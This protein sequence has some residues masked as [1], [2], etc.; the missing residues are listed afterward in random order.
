M[1]S[2]EYLSA[3]DDEELEKSN[4]GTAKIQQQLQILQSLIP[5][6]NQTDSRSIIE[7]ASDYLRRIHEEIEK[8]EKEL[9]SQRSE[10]DIGSSS[11]T[12]MIHNGSSSTSSTAP[13][14]LRVETEKV[15]GGFVV[16]MIWKKGPEV[17]GH[18]QRL[19]ES[20]ELVQLE[21]KMNS[22]NLKD[23][24]NPHEMI[25]TAFLEVMDEKHIT[26]EELYD[27]IMGT[28]TRL[29]LVQ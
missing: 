11:G 3:S 17:A 16:K 5:N 7:D 19:I 14:I 12:R 18:V 10:G 2:N 8:A 15:G 22:I 21:V 1:D 13:H 27:M 20:L 4:H 6:S 29:G 9:S 25:T 24:N 23:N 26:E 28:A